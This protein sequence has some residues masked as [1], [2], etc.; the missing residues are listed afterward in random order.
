MKLGF[1]FDLDGV[2]VNTAKYHFQAWQRLA[3]TLGFEFTEKDN[4]KL[5]GIS[6]MESLDILLA[7]G[8]ITLSNREKQELADRKNLWYL[9][10]IDQ[11]TPA[12][13]LPGA[14]S[15]L[16][17]AI[18]LGFRT[19][20]GSASKNAQR[21]LDRLAIKDQFTVIV[22]GTMVEHAKPNP[23]VF[24]LAAKK[25]ELST[26]KC[27]VF[28]D[29]EAGIVAAKNAGMLAIGIGS[30]E[31]LKRADKIIVGLNEITIEQAAEMIAGPLAY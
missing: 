8:G 20:L 16:T 2:I 7:I 17:E 13:I 30:K 5:K 25:M 29:A 31:N 11:L 26:S 18:S 27:L 12:D 10:L 9:E 6:R 21:I 3:N 28:E 15:L 14:N 24:L 22:D 1:I 19:A 23:E 4:E